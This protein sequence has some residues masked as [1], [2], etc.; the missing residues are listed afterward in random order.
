[1]GGFPTFAEAMVEGEVAPIPD[2]PCLTVNG[3]VRPQS[4]PLR[5]TLK[6]ERSPVGV[7]PTG[8]APPY[9]GARGER[10][11]RS[12]A[13]VEDFRIGASV[14]EP[15]QS[16]EVCRWPLCFTEARVAL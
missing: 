1:M 8:K 5:A 15:G 2:L 12:G 9:H 11:F 16:E 7:A 10:T 13:K 4:E 14:A 6:L 3:E